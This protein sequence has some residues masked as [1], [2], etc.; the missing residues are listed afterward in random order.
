MYVARRAMLRAPVVRGG[1]RCAHHAAGKAADR[2]GPPVAGPLA[3]TEVRQAATGGTD[4][5]LTGDL[6]PLPSGSAKHMK[7]APSAYRPLQR[8]SRRVPEP[9]AG[10]SGAAG[11]D[12]G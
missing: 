9:V 1:P 2:C 7:A 6:R 3:P 8:G 11:P 12:S 5:V 10:R 4:A